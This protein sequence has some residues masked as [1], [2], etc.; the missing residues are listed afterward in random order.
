MKENL[1]AN[2]VQRCVAAVLVLLLV[3]PALI[4]ARYRPTQGTNAFSK[5]DEIKAGQDA[6]AQVR[7]QL[8]VLK[9][10]DPIVQYVQRLGR[11]LAA[12]APGEKWPYNFHVV[13]K[14]EINAFA[15]PGG[16]IYVNLGTI[17]AA[18]NEAQL[19][20]VMAHEISHVVQRHATRA[21]TKQ[22]Y[23]QVPLALLGSLLG[24]STGGQLAQLGVQFGV[25]SYFLKNSR[26]AESEAD[27]IGTD[28]LYDSGYDPHAMAEFFQKLEASGGA[29][30]PQFL[31]DHPNPGNRAAMVAKEVR[32][33]PPKQF[34]RDSNE[35]QNVKRQVAGMKAPSV[36]QIA[37]QRKQ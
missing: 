29:R 35:F 10:S 5:P 27:L 9:D 17:Q 15:L 26:E 30:G 3:N 25:G 1:R 34:R 14:K 2:L 24:R 16:P 12:H 6:S 31:S 32:T 20:G 36:Q 7:K 37:Q 8:P 33:L 28:I 11:N 22:M 18:D 19:A 13:S 21:A 4:Q 23:A